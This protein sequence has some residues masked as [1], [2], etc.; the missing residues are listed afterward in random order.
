MNKLLIV[1]LALSFNVIAEE[2]KDNDKHYN[3][4]RTS[5]VAIGQAKQQEEHY[6]NQLLFTPEKGSNSQRM[7]YE[8]QLTQ[9][10]ATREMF[11]KMYDTLKCSKYFE[12]EKK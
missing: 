2:T 4:C 1:L 10:K 11:E 3:T 12:V 5:E 8:S 9:L 7:M 6:R